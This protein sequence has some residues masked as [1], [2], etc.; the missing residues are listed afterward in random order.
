M[1]H[2][3][4]D[5]FHVTHPAIFWHYSPWHCREL[6][7]DPRFSQF[8]IYQQNRSW[9]GFNRITRHQLHVK[10]CES[11]K[12][13]RT[14]SFWSVGLGYCRIMNNS[15]NNSG[16][17]FYSAVSHRQGWA[18][19]TSQDQKMFS[20]LG[21]GM[22]QAAVYQV[23]ANVFVFKKEEGGKYFCVRV[24]KHIHFLIPPITESSRILLTFFNFFPPRVI[25]LL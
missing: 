4:I 16:S 6:S 5:A 3:G 20:R 8:Q 21:S 18:H 17:N 15:N 9:L 12:P 11:T 14:T 19:R 2:S 22:S 13:H 7:F 24:G 1:H 25:W 10:T 23:C